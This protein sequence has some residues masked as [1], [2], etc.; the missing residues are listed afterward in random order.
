[1]R[2]PPPVP[3]A[4]RARDLAQLGAAAGREEDGDEPTGR[5]APISFLASSASR[6]T[7][8]LVLD[9]FTVNFVCEWFGY[10]RDVI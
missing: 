2:H 6:A 8:W 10:L 4:Q 7:V 5:Y 3:V 9:I 1:M